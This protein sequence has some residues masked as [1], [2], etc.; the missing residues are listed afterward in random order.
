MPFIAITEAVFSAVA[1]ARVDTME[2]ITALMLDGL[3]MD[4]LLAEMAQI[5]DSAL[6]LSDADGRPLAST[7]D[8]VAGGPG[9]QTLPVVTGSR[10][11]GS[12]W[13]GR[14][15]AAT[16]SCCTTSRPCWPSTW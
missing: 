3:D 11:A 15:R 8:L 12:C 5:A 4:A 2:R 14:E 13:R 1:G 9:V 7:A 10:V 6:A 16:A